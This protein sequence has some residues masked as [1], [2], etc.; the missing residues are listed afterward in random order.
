[1]HGVRSA[2][3]QSSTY[4]PHFPCIHMTEERSA[5]LDRRVEGGGETMTR[6]E[7][8]ETLEGWYIQHDMYTMKVARVAS[9]ASG[10]AGGRRRGKRRLVGGADRS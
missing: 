10:R 8:P 1:M 5:A 4:G 9:H 3:W 6:S 2:C 7:A